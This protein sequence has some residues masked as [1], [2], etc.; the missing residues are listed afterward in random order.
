MYKSAMYEVPEWSENLLVGVEQID[1]Q[2]QYFVFLIHQ[3]KVYIDRGFKNISAYDILTEIGS[4]ARFHFKSEENFM[5]EYNYPKLKEQ[6]DEHKK[7]IDEFL[8]E[9][10]KIEDHP[11]DLMN[12]YDFLLKWFVDHT[13]SKDLEIGE[14]I[15][16]Q[17]EKGL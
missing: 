6:E 17:R 14:F 7:L 5:I 9:S 8:V 1:L 3:L 16:E 10:V 4:Y 11:R 13:S 12:M 2:H 15:K